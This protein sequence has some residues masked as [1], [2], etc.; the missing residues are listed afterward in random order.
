[1]QI[2]LLERV[3]KLGQMGDTVNVKPGYARNFLLPNRKALR[4]TKENIERFDKEKGWTFHGHEEIGRR[5]LKKVAKRI[6]ESIYYHGIFSYVW[7]L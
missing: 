3:E 6:C 5:M 2:I 4:A 1:M 7:G